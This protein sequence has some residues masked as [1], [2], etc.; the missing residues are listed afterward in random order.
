MSL[1]VVYLILFKSRTHMAFQDFPDGLLLGIS[2]G[3]I[4][5]LCHNPTCERLLIEYLKYHVYPFLQIFF[6]GC[7]N[8]LKKTF[9]NRPNVAE[10]VLQTASSLVH[11]LTDSL[12]VCENIFTAPP[13][14][15]GWKCCFQ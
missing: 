1:L 15:N 14:P 5:L 13:R 7:T 6:L 10:A 4:R 2:F 3:A 12:M 8:L 11:Y 9:I